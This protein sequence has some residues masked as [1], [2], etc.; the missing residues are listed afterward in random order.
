M[1]VNLPLLYGLPSLLDR[2]MNHEED[3]ALRADPGG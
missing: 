2:L 3:T 1:P